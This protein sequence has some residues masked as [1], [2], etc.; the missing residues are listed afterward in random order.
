MISEMSRAEAGFGMW[1][2]EETRPRPKPRE[3][4]IVLVIDDNPFSRALT[5]HGLE[6]LGWEAL[7][8]PDVATGVAMFRESNRRIAAVVLDLETV[9][10]D[11]RRVLRELRSLRR[12]VPLIVCGN[13]SAGAAC[14]RFSDAA[15]ADFL[16]RPF[17]HS[18]LHDV[19][20]RAVRGN[21]ARGSLT[22]LRALYS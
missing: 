20:H 12:D 1:W 6:S 16:A 2:E 14:R 21:P 10:S 4:N 8:A 18:D 9:E 5:G 3:R 13:G 7:L 22:P 19:L 11:D 15:G 17:S